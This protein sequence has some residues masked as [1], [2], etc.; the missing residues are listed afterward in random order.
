MPL[1]KQGHGSRR[2][3]PKY[4]PS[5]TPARAGSRLYPTPPVATSP[6]QRQQRTPPPPRK[7]PEPLRRAVADCLSAAASNLHSSSPVPSAESART[8]RD[9]IANPSTT[10]MAYT[11]LLEHALAERDRSPAVVS[12]CVALLKRY[13]LRYIPKVQ[14]LRHIDI[15][16][17]Y[18]MVECE[19]F[20]NPRGSLWSKS[21]SQ[22]PRTL[23]V[24]VNT[25]FPSPHVSS[26]APSSLVKS[27]SYVRSLVARHIPKLSFQPLA[28][29]GFSASTKQSLPNLSSILSRSL[30][31]HLSPEVVDS[32]ES[33]QRKEGSAQ[34]T[35]SVSNLDPVDEGDRNRTISF[36]LLTW[37]WS[38]SREHQPSSSTRESDGVLG[39]QDARMHGFLEVG[40]A[41]LLIGDID[42]KSKDQAWKYSMT[43]HLPVIDQL[44][45]PST[46][47]S[48]SNI[49]SIH[50]HLKAITGSKRLKLGPEQLWANLPV[51][52]YHPRA[53]PLFQYRHYSE[54]QPLRL[55]PA[56]ISEVI[57]EVCL[58]SSSPNMNFLSTMSPLTKNN[59][60][61]STDVAASVLI[62]LVIDMYM[63]DAGTAAPLTVSMLE[64]MLD[65]QRVTS[66]TRVFDIIL[67]LGVHAHLLEPVMH[68]DPPT[69]EEEVP[70]EPSLSSADL[71][72]MG[73]IVAEKKMQQSKTLAIDKFESWILLIL[74]E[75]LRFLV[76]TQEQEEIVWASALSCLFYFVCDRGKILRSRLEGLDIRVIKTL[77]E[78]S[79]KH[80]WAEIIHCRLICM[81]TNMF[82]QAPNGSADAISD[83]PIFL[84]EQIDLL[85]G[86]DFICLEYSQANSREEKRNLFLVLLDFVLHQIK[87]TSSA[88][89]VSS[90]V[91][92]EIQLVASML[93]LADAPE[94][95][96]I[97]VKHGV[98]GIGEILRRPISA[99][100]SKTSNYE[101]LDL[102]LDKITRKLDATICTFTRLDDEFSDMIQ[103][104]KSY[105]SL[106]CIKDG[107][108]GADI[109]MQVQLAWATLHSL[110]H[111]ERSTYHHHGYIWL[112]ELLLSEINDYRD[113]SIWEN[114]GKLQEQI[115]AAANQDI[116]TS[117]SVPL[118]ISI[119]C[120]LLKSKHNH[121]RWGFLFVM[122]KLLM[123]LK[124]LLDESELDNRNHEDAMNYDHSENHL[125]KANSV[126]E[127]MS[128]ALSL[129]VQIN[130]T[131][132][133]NILK[134]CDILFSQL[135]LRTHCA[136]EIPPEDFQCSNYHYGYTNEYCEGEIATHVS[137]Y[138]QE[139]KNLYKDEL[140]GKTSNGARINQSDPSYE[141]ASMAA[142][143]LR[144]HATVPMQLVARVP[145]SLFYWP[146]IQ[147]AGAATDDIAL[148]VA[149]GSKGGGNLPGSTSDIR[150]ALLLLLIG[151][152][153]ADS[154]AFL[155]VEGEEF[156]RGLLDDTD[157]RVAY[158]TSAFLLKRM[159]T[160]EPEDYQRM[161]QNLIIK[162]QQSNNEKL[163][164]NPYLQMRGIL[165]LSNDP[166]A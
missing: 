79:S 102:L 132:R 80:F 8:L 128:C 34:S 26:S 9:Y 166:G 157:S 73:Q 129:L 123:R 20:T 64:N 6:S 52:T 27:L 36:D 66:R 141:T 159:M 35:L 114:I 146:L 76:Q 48:A 127:I 71:Q 99:A 31:S 117:S 50:S 38:G 25:S 15:F 135:C 46:A 67:N 16:C 121:I 142:L 152:C 85:G 49:V 92:D 22:Q 55:N 119:L 74:F 144:G 2:T 130:E 37:R 40:A 148:D 17:E 164:E 94:A 10:D 139:M 87:E 155:E 28:Q 137:Q 93:S 165:Q 7:P 59:R 153:S 110:L 161:L 125:K 70:Q 109:R 72:T 69:I 106:D 96:Y 1:D 44:L 108:G 116:T 45:E 147:L 75:I 95:F 30:T 162:A 120:G 3:P 83:S 111:S 32:R 78:V 42:A 11:F 100:M 136:K 60:R 156:F 51:S 57:A 154:I 77:L 62:K 103:I 133:I 53:R 12:R 122:E 33:P 84:S 97:A 56:E 140:P 143:L 24:A 150:A 163:L 149:V 126:I 82:Y 145:T 47:I 61:P 29:S 23:P 105:S 13:L 4:S 41:A 124:L 98:E 21:L 134:M 14:T 81:L 89:G 43:Q 151:K 63:M 19:S 58:E 104:T 131:D 68:E 5:R 112:A 39:P 86:I 113:R 18:S 158:Y 118:S 54:Q 88:A 91:Y 90:F 115:G 160:E 101:R 65:S 107:L 138:P